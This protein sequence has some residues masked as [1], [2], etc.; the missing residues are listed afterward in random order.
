MQAGVDWLGL[1][2]LVGRRSVSMGFMARR[3]VTGPLWKLHMVIG[4]LG[5]M[6]YRMFKIADGLEQENRKIR[7]SDCC[8][9]YTKNLD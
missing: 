5:Y 3:L 7:F 2:H 1:Y 6:A 9:T 4:R 8:R